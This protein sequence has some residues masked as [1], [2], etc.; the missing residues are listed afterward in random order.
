MNTHLSNS[1]IPFTL[2]RTVEE[3][4]DTFT[5]MIYLEFLLL[6]DV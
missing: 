3:M 6:S 5:S 1:S 4:I 2:K